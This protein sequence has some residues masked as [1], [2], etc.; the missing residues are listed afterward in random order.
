VFYTREDS[1][2]DQGLLQAYAKKD[3]APE[4][5][6]SRAE[7]PIMDD[8]IEVLSG[9]EG[10]EDLV[11]KLKKYT[12]G[13]FAGLF[14]Q[15]TNVEA[16]N[17]L[18]IFSV[19][20]LE[21]ELRPMAVYNIISYIWNIVRSEMKKRIMVIDEAWWLMQY[22]DSAKFM[23]ALVK[24]CR[25]YYLGVTTI[26]QDV[27]DFLN[28]SYGKAIVTNSS[29]QFLM[30]QSKAGIDVVTET[31]KLTEGEKYLLLESAVGEGIFFAGAKHAAIKVVA[32]YVED[33]IITSDP[34]QLLEIEQSKREFQD[35]IERGEVEYGK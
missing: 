11:L 21:D 32:S 10:A 2:L 34:A 23:Y 14:N 29:M 22:E 13:T 19:R 24:R 31:F 9:M 3:I 4:A 25:K 7:P 27:S 6:L 15:H 33:Q 8:F 12:E 17:Q 30:R 16:R 20:D 18:V 35:A 1:L 26:T 5:D 28:S